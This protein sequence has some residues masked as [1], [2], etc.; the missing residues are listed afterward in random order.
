MHIKMFVLFNRSTLY[1]IDHNA[2][3]ERNAYCVAAVVLGHSSQVGICTCIIPNNLYLY[4]KQ[5]IMK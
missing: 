2:I 3:V 1:I 4:F 5:I